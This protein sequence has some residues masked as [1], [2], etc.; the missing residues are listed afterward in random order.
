MLVTNP[1]AADIMSL[2]FLTEQRRHGAETDR[3]RR[4]LEALIRSNRNVTG[5]GQNEEVEQLADELG[6]DSHELACLDVRIRNRR[7]T[8]ACVPSR[9]WN[10]PGAMA[11]FYELKSA[12]AALGHRVILVP[13]GFIRRQPRLDNAFMVSDAIDIQI[14]ASD[15][16]AILEFMIENGEGTLSDVASLVR[17]PDPVAAILHLVTVGVLDID[18]DAPIRPT[19]EVRFANAAE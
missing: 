10:R 15:R 18:L 11:T 14:N 6:L 1:I 5:L 8:I 3:L 16:M 4:G 12:A 2:P 19:S 7:A 13:A 17:H 9:L